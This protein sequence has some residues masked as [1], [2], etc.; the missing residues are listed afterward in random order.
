MNQLSVIFEDEDLHVSQYVHPQQADVTE[1]WHMFGAF[2]DDS[3]FGLKLAKTRGAN[4]TFYVPKKNVWYQ[5]SRIEEVIQAAKAGLP[6]TAGMNVINYGSSMGGFAAC[7]FAGFSGASLVIAASPQ[8]SIDPA[9]VQNNDAR[10]TDI[11]SRLKHPYPD[12]R[13]GLTHCKRV[14]VLFDPYVLEDKWHVDQLQEA[15]QIEGLAFPSA[16]HGVLY[17]LKESGILKPLITSL[18]DNMDV[19]AYFTQ[20]QNSITQTFGYWF[21]KAKLH[22]QKGEF[23]QAEQDMH[24]ASKIPGPMD[25]VYS[26]FADICCQRNQLSSAIEYA[27]MAKDAAPHIGGH[28]VKAAQI[29]DLAGEVVQAEKVLLQCIE[30]LP[31]CGPAYSILA[32]FAYRRK[33]KFAAIR[34]MKQAVINGMGTTPWH[35][36]LRDLYAE[37]GD[38][39]RA[40]QQLAMAQG[41]FEPIP[42]PKPVPPN[43][44]LV[45]MYQNLLHPI[46]L[47]LK[48][49]RWSK[50]LLFNFLEID[51]QDPA[52]HIG[53]WS[54]ESRRSTIEEN[55]ISSK[56]R[57]P[58]FYAKA[59]DLEV[60][61]GV[62]GYVCIDI[63]PSYANNAELLV[64]VSSLNNA[65]ILF[66]HGSEWFTPMFDLCGDY[67]LG[68]RLNGGV[69]SILVRRENQMQDAHAHISIATREAAQ[70]SPKAIVID[71]HKF[72]YSQWPPKEEHFFLDHQDG[73]IG[74]FQRLICHTEQCTPDALLEKLRQHEQFPEPKLKYIIFFMPR[75]GS[76]LLTQV[77]AKSQIF[78]NPEEFFLPFCYHVYSRIM[79]CDNP[80]EYLDRIERAFQ[81]KHGVFGME[82]D[83]DRF[84]SY[85]KYYLEDRLDGY[86]KFYMDRK[87]FLAHFVSQFF[88]SV[89][90]IW[91]DVKGVEKPE[92]DLLE[93]ITPENV[94]LVFGFLLRQKLGWD[95]YL[96]GR[97]DVV[98]IYYEDVVAKSGLKDILVDLLPQADLWPEVE[99]KVATGAYYE[100]T[101]FVPTSSASKKEVS[102]SILALLESDERVPVL[103]ECAEGRNV[104]IPGFLS[105]FAEDVKRAV[106][107]KINL[108]PFVTGA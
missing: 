89:A 106:E 103:I 97:N 51:S 100:D 69:S 10:W 7:A 55:F 33:D 46:K 108:Y 79:A 59:L 107:R 84:N 31:D 30:K 67:L 29:L 34:Y 76:T 50:T 98:R 8:I 13:A 43:E 95:E 102:K 53:T 65:L 80:Y 17:T 85:W 41:R 94:G 25:E 82:V 87:D 92:H 88:A 47:G 37:L 27:S 14:V 63:P 23:D 22:Y 86:I 42:T 12:A 72:G 77:L 99:K 49:N 24:H 3:P 62:G 54:I 35:M 15:F 21:T 38:Q 75:S 11:G 16:G 64:S 45:V 4:A 9:V 71:N 81:S 61:P 52:S 18:A 39:T 91:F 2:G 93:K 73:T 78:G 70:E 60:I 74:P 40:R 6:Q 101:F 20:Y 56:I 5:T 32:D 44:A 48:A 19:S 66:V 26:F 36:V 96:Q 105:P 1:E 68:P 83:F 104:T 58:D 28:Y 57:K 90:D